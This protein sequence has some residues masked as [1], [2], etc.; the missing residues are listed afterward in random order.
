[1]LNEFKRARLIKGLKQ[2]KVAE[3]L[4]VSCVAVSCWEH[5]KSLPSPERFQE[6]ATLLGTTVDDLLAG[7]KE[8][9]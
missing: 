2:K 5:G 7:R 8:A 4:G 6:V 3:L 9:G 1:M